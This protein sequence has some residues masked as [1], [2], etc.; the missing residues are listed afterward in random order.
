MKIRRAT[1]ADLPAIVSILAGDTLGKTREDDSPVMSDAY[2][3]AF[4]IISGEK[5]QT[6]LVAE[7]EEGEITGTLQLTFI[8]YLTYKGGL[9]A[10]AEAVF[11]KSN[12][13]GKG[14]GT[15]LMKE[16]EKISRER[17]AHLIQL[18][19]DKR[20][21]DAKRFYE[22]LGYTASHEGMKLHFKDLKP[23]S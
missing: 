14:I 10:Q 11:V 18:T 12:H 7:T 23:G 20:R 4:R 17:G 5:N 16:A 9:R 2:Q 13:R 19:T 21:P 8:Q 3:R 6:I 15:M 22:K 1:E